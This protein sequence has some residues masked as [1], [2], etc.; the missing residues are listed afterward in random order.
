MD[1]KPTASVM[2]VVGAN[3]P[4]PIRS[5]DGPQDQASFGGAKALDRQLAQT[6][7]VRPSLVEDARQKVSLTEYPPPE[8]INRIA[9]LLALQLGPDEQTQ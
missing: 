2:S 4:R 6:P 5:V 1:V 8:V 7:D 9:R 3:L